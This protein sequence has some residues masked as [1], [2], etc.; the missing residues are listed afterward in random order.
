M[1]SAEELRAQAPSPRLSSRPGAKSER[2]TPE[3]RAYAVAAVSE[4]RSIAK[5]ST[6]LGIKAWNLQKWVQAARKGV[7]ARRGR[8]PKALAEFRKIKLFKKPGA[9]SWSA[10]LFFPDGT[11]QTMETSHKEKREANMQAVQAWMRF[12]REKGI[13]A[14]FARRVAVVAEVEEPAPKLF[15]RN[16]PKGHALV[17]RPVT[18]P[19]L[20]RGGSA[21]IQKANRVGALVYV[22]DVLE[23][24]DPADAVWVARAAMGVAGVTER[25][26]VYASGRNGHTRDSSDWGAEIVAHARPGRRIDE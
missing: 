11:K 4:G 2:Y 16:K 1:L 18:R 26:Q 10:R 5:T 7:P 13:V 8:P 6:V 21:D 22:L 25:E 15:G 3:Y 19:M 12:G 24:L 17:T 20:P 23:R 9:R 14:P